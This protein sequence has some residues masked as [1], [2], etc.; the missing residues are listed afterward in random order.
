MLHLCYGTNVR[1]SRYMDGNFE[2]TGKLSLLF[3]CGNIVRR[4]VM[5]SA[6][7]LGHAWTIVING[8][9]NF[10]CVSYLVFVKCR[11]HIEVTWSH[12]SCLYV[13]FTHT[14]PVTYAKLGILIPQST[15]HRRFGVQWTFLWCHSIN[16]NNNSSNSDTIHCH[17]IFIQFIRGANKFFLHVYFIAN[18]IHFEMN[19]SKYKELYHAL[20]PPHWCVY[21]PKAMANVV[22]AS[23]NRIYFLY[24]DYCFSITIGVA[25]QCF[26]QLHH[27]R[28]GS[29]DFN[30]F[31][32]NF[33]TNGDESVWTI[34]T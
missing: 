24:Y 31:K 28:S 33:Q 7:A 4:Y 15:Y 6:M 19:V 2:A 17:Y 20:L 32:R 8:W 27:S 1:L 13:H 30:D 5:L 18:R 29:L 14:R 10:Y 23:Q 25:F 22:V 34:E 26:V 9:M 12:D 3:Q 16:K 21:I 11:I